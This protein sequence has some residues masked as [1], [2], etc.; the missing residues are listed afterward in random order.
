MMLRFVNIVCSSFL[1]VATT[2]SNQL[3][4]ALMR[5]GIPYKFGFMLITALRF[6]P[7]FNAELEQVKNAHKAKG[8]ELEGLSP[9]NLLRLIRYV[10]VP[11]V[12]SA[13][14]RVDSLTISMEGRA[15]GLFPTRSYLYSHNL[16]VKDKIA[17]LAIPVIFL[18][19][20][21]IS[22]F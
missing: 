20:C 18:L 2:D 4:Y 11:L 12:I 13:L 7:V 9:K 3:A 5:S 6:I 21:F 1:F 19:F 8:I 10:L 16:S 15:F 17:I 22:H 14:S